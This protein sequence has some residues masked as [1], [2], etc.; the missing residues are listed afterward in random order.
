MGDGG[1]NEERE[2]VEEEG[3]CAKEKGTGEKETGKT[4]LYP[5]WLE[6]QSMDRH[7]EQ[8]VIIDVRHHLQ[9]AASSSE[10]LSVFK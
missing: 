5:D 7:A 8:N 9:P 10:Q 1:E 2:R 4:V 6:A 3:K